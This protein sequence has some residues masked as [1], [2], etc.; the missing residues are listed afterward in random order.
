MTRRPPD[1]TVAAIGAVAAIAFV[2]AW[3]LLHVGWYTRDQIKDTPVYQRYGEAIERGEVPY[4]DFPVEYPPGALPVFALPALASRNGDPQSYRTAFEALM[5][6]AG[7]A[8]VLLVVLTLSRVGAGT[9]RLLVAGLVAALAPLALGSVVVSRFDVLAAA[10]T[11][12]AL[13]ALV[14]DRI[15]LAAVL[16]GAAIAVKLFPAVLL[17]L[18]AVHVARGRG[19]REGWITAAVAAGV[20]VLSYLPFALLS[21]GGVAHSVWRQLGRPLQIESLGAGVLLGLH[22]VAGLHL[23]WD[24]SHGSQ[25]LTGSGAGAVAIA[26]SLVQLALLVWIWVDYARG[27]AEP[28]RLLRYSAAAIV[29]FVALGKVLSPQF[30]IWLV[31]VVV[32]VRGRRGLVAGALLVAACVLTQLWF[33]YRY[34]RLV[35]EFDATASWLVLARDV[36][37]VAL[38][39][40]LLRARE[41]GAAR[42]P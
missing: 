19:R 2:A 42:S 16:L 15:R 34:W 4:R 30:L 41:P 3:G 18:V 35:Y 11:V 10:V 26:L 25:N 8:A 17:P 37:L 12:A 22:Q 39:V 33:P 24:S 40:V 5:A 23:G 27:P 38:L 7:M 6:A 20:V 1:A 28:E 32:L 21:P 13:A 36:V 9:G 31:P 14:S 29:A